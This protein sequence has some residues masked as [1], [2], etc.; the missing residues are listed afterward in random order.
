MPRLV[1]SSL[2]VFLLTLGMGQG[3]AAPAGDP[4]AFVDQLI[5]GDLQSLSDKQLSDQ[6]RERRF[7]TILDRDFDLPRIARFVL[8]RYW[9]G[10]AEPDRQ[11]FVNS[12]K[13]WTVHAYSSRFSGY[14][15]DGVKVTSARPES[16]TM[17]TVASEVAVTSGA[18]PITIHWRVR[19]DKG[20]GYK[21]VDVDFGG[22]SLLLL[23]R[24]Q[25]TSLLEQSG[26]TV[27]GLTHA[28]D[29]KVAAGDTGAAVLAH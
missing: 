7:A 24:E 28:L 13:R 22:I 10:A 1:L 15:G 21:V 18:P 5:H 17:F 2:V 12:F 3:L 26:G 9:N 14:S 19:D 8:G 4:A 25:F 23:E 29:E 20:D 27:A 16:E 11:G 6:E